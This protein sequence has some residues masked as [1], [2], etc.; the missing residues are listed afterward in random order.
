MNFHLQRLQN[1]ITGAVEGL[2][3]EQLTWCRE[4]KWN[5]AEILEHLYLTYT[6]TIKG[7]ERCLAAGKPI[8]RSVNW[9]DRIKTLVV[10]GCGY[11]PEGRQSPKQ[12]VPHGVFPSLPLGEILSQIFPRISEM[13]AVI[14]RSIQGFGS[15]VALL[16]HPIL[17]PLRG[18]EWCKFHWVHG[19]HHVRQ[20]VRLREL[21]AS[22]RG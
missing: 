13:D 17:G 20:I 6:G 14:N 8:A 19:H 22:S 1:D 3:P 4:G 9:S 11:L 10:V 18:P 2:T 12:A 21:C 7:F 15:S 16:D 5:I